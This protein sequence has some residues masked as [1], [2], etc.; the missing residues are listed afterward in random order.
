MIKKLHDFVHCR[1]KMKKAELKESVEELRN[2]GRG[3]YQI[4]TFSAEE[5]VSTEE[6]QWC[7]GDMDTLALVFIDIGYYREQT[8]DERC[9]ANINDILDFFSQSGMD[10]ILRI[11][12]D[13][14]GKA[15]E[16]EPYSFSQVMEHM[17]QLGPVLSRYAEHIYIYQGM[18]VGSW[19]EMHSSRFLATAQMERLISALENC[20]ERH[21]FLAVRRPSHW[22]TLHLNGESE[23]GRTRVGL[24]DDG[25]FGSDT[26]LGTFGR[27]TADEA[28]WG[29]AWSVEEE[30]AFEEKLCRYVPQGGEVLYEE[31]K[32][33]ER[34]LDAT[35]ERLRRMHI[36]Y[37]NRVHDPRILELW[38]RMTWRE[39]GPWEGMNGFDY[40]G[41]HLGYRFCVRN[42]TVKFVR[43]KRNAQ[44]Q[45][46]WEISIEN[47][48]FS[49]CYQKARAW[50]EWKNEEGQACTKELLPELSCIL[51]GEVKKGT[52]TTVPAKGEVRLFAAREQDGH[53]I[54]L[55]NAC[56]GGQGVLLGRMVPPSGS[57]G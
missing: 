36:S 47:V 57:Q 3:W 44:V 40:I 29:A 33:E 6:L 30:L 32:A 41:R 46:L 7:L 2:P 48:G 16:R 22:R 11:A 28:G 31:A 12:Y 14:Q 50:L 34:S 9:L 8:L 38:K 24:F 4:H 21:V 53:A 18:L 26:H 45:C 42:V 35:V 23:F 39:R 56:E 19:G 25:I 55:A 17:K 37:L 15:W 54:C 51:P 10:M 49:P 13:R 52:C 27:S 5:E 1:W 20:L 43:E